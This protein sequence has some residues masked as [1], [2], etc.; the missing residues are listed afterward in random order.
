MFPGYV[1]AFAHSNA[2]L[3]SHDLPV[4]SRV[5]DRV[6]VMRQGRMVERGPTD[7]VFIEPQHDYT[8]G[9]VAAARRLQDALDGDGGS[10]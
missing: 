2:L 9:L 10:V 5:A 6:L 8:K 3:V 1:R 4:V 7:R